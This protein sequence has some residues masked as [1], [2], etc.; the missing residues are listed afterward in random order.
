MCMAI[1]RDTLS[2][3]GSWKSKGWT[4]KCETASQ[5]NA[6]GARQYKHLV[7]APQPS[8]L[9]WN[10]LWK[11]NWSDGKRERAPRRRHE[12]KLTFMKLQLHVGLLHRYGFTLLLPTSAN[13]MCSYTPLP[14]GR[15]ERNAWKHHHCALMWT[16]VNGWVKV[17]LKMHD[18]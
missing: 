14:H 5:I 18:D 12:V 7:P 13:V 3:L 11:G 17:P 15:E 4:Q 9:P 16:T 10:V 1:Q 2:L 8:H 6:V